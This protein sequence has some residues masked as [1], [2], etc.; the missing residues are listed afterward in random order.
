MKSEEIDK[1]L[2]NVP[3]P[4]SHIE[5]DLGMPATILQ[6]ALRGK[7]NLPKKWAIAL[8]LYVETKQYLLSGAIP[9]IPPSKR[10]VVEQVVKE[11]TPKEEKS[12]KTIVPK[13][14]DPK[15]GS[16]AFYSKY[17][18]ATYAEIKKS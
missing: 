8:R 16:M 9:H 18:V 5:R 12:T 14:Y 7:R 17:G 15:E 4:I 3:N 2:E 1:L 10:E 11:P 6:K 13:K